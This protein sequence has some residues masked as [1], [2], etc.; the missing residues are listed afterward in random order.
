MTRFHYTNV[1]HPKQAVI[2]GMTRD[3]LFLVEGGRISGPV[4]DLRFTQGY[5]EA[6]DGVEAVGDAR[7]GASWARS[8]RRCDRRFLHRTTVDT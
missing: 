1:V 8:C 4:R 7:P 2:T 3:G 5:L 6:L